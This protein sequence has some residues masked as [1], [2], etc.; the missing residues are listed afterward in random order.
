MVG[1]QPELASVG[2]TFA[3]GAAVRRIRVETVVDASYW[4]SAAAAWGY[5]SA[6]VIM[7][8]KVRRRNTAGQPTA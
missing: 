3:T 8:L 5:A 1:S 7:N 2:G 6:E 4:T